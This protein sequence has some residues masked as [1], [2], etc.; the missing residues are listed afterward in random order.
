MYEA[1]YGLRERP[2]SILPDP[3][4]LYPSRCH[5]TAIAMMEYGLTQGAGFVVVTGGVGTGKTTLIRH[6]VGQLDDRCTVGLIAN[7]HPAWGGMLGRV[8][9]AFEIPCD[10]R[11]PLDLMAELERFLGRQRLGGRSCLLLLDEA[12]ILDGGALEE[13]R[14]ISNVN[15]DTGF[16]QVMLVGQPALRETLAA[17]ALEQFAQRI[18]VDYHLDPLDRE[19]T[20][21]YVAHRVAVAGGNGLFD[22]AACDRLFEHSGGVP[23][24]INVLCEN[25]L[26][27][28]FAAGRGSIDAETVAEVVKDRRR[29]AMFPL[30]AGVE[31]QVD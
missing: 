1:F 7:P 27:Y 9:A 17:P 12:Q 24:I 14:L 31:A 4:F 11:D 16:L 25:A 6:L 23:R 29:G 10:S 8:L 18:V 19:E 3:A 21:T 28:G 5:R 30:R 2:F 22:P 15:A 20:H 13:L 26:V